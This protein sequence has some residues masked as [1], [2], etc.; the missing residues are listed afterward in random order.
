MQ[1]IYCVKCRSANPYGHDFCSECGLPLPQ[2]HATGLSL[3]A[4]TA[5]GSDRYADMEDRLLALNQTVEELLKYI[6]AVAD[7]Y[8]QDISNIDDIH[9]YIRDVNVE[10]EAVEEFW[11]NSIVGYLRFVENRFHLMRRIEA[12]V[13]IYQGPRKEFLRKLI[14]RAQIHFYARQNSKCLKFIERGLRMSPDNHELLFFLGEKLYLMN[15]PSKAIG[16]WSQVLNLKPGHY[17]ASLMVGI[18]KLINGDCSNARHLLKDATRQTDNGVVPLLALA[19]LEYQEGCFIESERYIKLA[20][21]VYETAFGHV[22]LAENLNK[23]EHPRKA[24]V[25]LETAVKMKPN[26]KRIL[27]RLATQYLHSGYIKRAKEL[28]SR[29]SSLNPSEPFF[30]DLASKKSVPE[31]IAAF[32]QQNEY[33]ASNI[34]MHSVSEL[35]INEL[36]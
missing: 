16:V 3:R 15:Q 27:V 9:Q 7:E 2:S 34:L 25:E 10:R 33:S 28:F 22:L 24:L 13:D 17:R 6:H 14:E 36:T 12:I 8:D 35:L 11:Q 4:D 26:D 20:N 29:I 21:R 32:E 19:T 18:L 5:D 1:T 31:I 23:Q 30:R